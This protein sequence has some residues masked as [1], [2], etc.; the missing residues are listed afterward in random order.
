ML[1][2]IVLPNGNESEF[3]SLAEKLGYDCLVFLYPSFR[4]LDELQKRTRIKL[5]P[6]VI[7]NAKKQ[8]VANDCLFFVKAEKDVRT[9]F[10]N[11][12]IDV[13]FG[14]ETIDGKDSLHQ[15]N[16]GLNHVTASLAFQ[17]DI[18]V[19][20]SFFDILCA[21]KK[22]ILIGRMAQN[23][24][25]CRKF[26]AKMIIAS[27]AREPFR[28]RAPLDLKSFFQTIGMGPGEAKKALECVYDLLIEK[29]NQHRIIKK[30]IE[31]VDF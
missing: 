4:R 12:T 24:R 30:G 21:D 1:A 20:F 17:K 19:G 25:L 10:E 16:S 22:E 11:K 23:I 13:V 27:F 29:K 18:V 2:D 26:K 31:L 28:M 6:G 5:M 14:L 8:I 9:V 3:I 7:A 15:R